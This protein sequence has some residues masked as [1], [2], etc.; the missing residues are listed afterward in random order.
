MDDPIDMVEKRL[1][2]MLDLLDTDTLCRALSKTMKDS[3]PAHRR[4]NVLLSTGIRAV[5]DTIMRS[6]R[7][8]RTTRAKNDLSHRRMQAIEH[9]NRE[10]ER[11]K[12]RG[13]R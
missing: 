1:V 8:I 10:R 9:D 13:V 5:D 12:Q 6:I 7:L 2:A 4:F 3:T 11:L